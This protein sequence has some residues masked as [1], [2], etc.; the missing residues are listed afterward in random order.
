MVGRLLSKNKH[1][2]YTPRNTTALCF[3]SQKT[4]SK[5]I[6]SVTSKQLTTIKQHRFPNINGQFFGIHLTVLMW[7]DKPNK[8]DT[9]NIYVFSS[10]TE[11][12]C[13]ASRLRERWLT[14]STHTNH[15][16]TLQNAYSQ[17][18]CIRTSMF[19]IYTL[20]GPN[21]QTTLS[22]F[23]DRFWKI[24]AR[25]SGSWVNIPHCPLIVQIISSSVKLLH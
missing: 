19:R 10:I 2:C 15:W 23:S 25:L 1:I 11:A 24:R 13:I 14:K 8:G 9:A 21:F 17:V 7:N 12:A 16:C 22:T 6:K 5:S 20:H 3:D 18:L 4:T